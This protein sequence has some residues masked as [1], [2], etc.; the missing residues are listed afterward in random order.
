MSDEKWKPWILGYEPWDP[1]C[2]PPVTREEF[3]EAYADRCG[4]GG[5]TVGR[6]ADGITFGDRKRV[7]LPCRCGEENCRGWAMISD[8]Q[9]SIDD[10]MEFY[11]T[12]EG[13]E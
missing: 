8:D 3:I 5:V 13:E 1:G 2:E 9:D 4:E 10:H 11:G 6:R 12:K 7:A